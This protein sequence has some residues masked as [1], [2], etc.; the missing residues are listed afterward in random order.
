[1]S[2]RQYTPLWRNARI[3]THASG[4]HA[5]SHPAILGNV[6]RHTAYI[7]LRSGFSQRT[8]WQH[9]GSWRILPLLLASRD[10]GGAALHATHVSDSLAGSAPCKHRSVDSTDVNANAL[11]DGTSRSPAKSKGESSY[12]GFRPTHFAVH[13]TWCKLKYIDRLLLLE[14]KG[15][16]KK[17]RGL[18]N[19]SALRRC[20]LLFFR[21]RSSLY[22]DTC[23]PKFYRGSHERSNLQVAVLAIEAAAPTCH[24]R[25]NDLAVAA[26]VHDFCMRRG[27]AFR[28]QVRDHGGRHAALLSADRTCVDVVERFQPCAHTETVQNVI[29]AY[30]SAATRT[31]NGVVL[32][33]PFHLAFF[34]SRL[35]RLSWHGLL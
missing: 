20:V 7:R 28:H 16:W 21:A 23:T 34:A 14:P 22:P 29:L 17:S 24:M 1:L 2:L 32:R 30:V 25:H 5:G 4:S 19:L 18:L 35:F 27:A 15:H 8:A 11:G 33:A 12:E 13:P 26:R 6:G 9:H 31:H 3:T 10:H